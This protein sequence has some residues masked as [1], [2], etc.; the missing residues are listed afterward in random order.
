[1][2]TFTVE[3]YA[4]LVKNKVRPVIKLLSPTVLYVKYEVITITYRYS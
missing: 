2:M 3:T 4:T 1:M